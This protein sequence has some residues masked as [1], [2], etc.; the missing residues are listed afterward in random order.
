[1]APVQLE[2]L[3]AINEAKTEGVVCGRIASFNVQMDMYAVAPGSLDKT[4]QNGIGKTPCLIIRHSKGPSDDTTVMDTVGFLKS[5]SVDENGYLAEF[6]MEPEAQANGLYR[7]AKGFSIGLKVLRS[8]VVGHVTIIEEAK[9]VHVLLTNTPM[10][11]DAVVM[12]N[13]EEPTAPPPVVVAAVV[14][15]VAPLVQPV[16]VVTDTQEAMVVREL[17]IQS[18]FKVNKQ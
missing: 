10:D 11:A 3:S 15:P 7:K 17:I 13:R 9:L 5:W 12:I 14:P 16:N 1:M 6:A 4:L 18:L 8:K 2:Y